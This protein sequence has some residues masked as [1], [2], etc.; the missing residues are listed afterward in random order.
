MAEHNFD[1]GKDRALEEGHSF[2]LGGVTFRT[3]A[4]MPP[5]VIAEEFKP[6]F[7]GVVDFLVKMVVPEDRAAFE[8]MIN[9]DTANITPDDCIDVSNWLLEVISERPTVA[10]GSPSAGRKTTSRTSTATDS[11]EATAGAKSA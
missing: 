9:A 1:E 4:S 11:E 3:K 5:K 2:V 6:G 7:A 8:H 10:P